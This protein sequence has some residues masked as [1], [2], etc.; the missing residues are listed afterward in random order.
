MSEGATLTNRIDAIL[1]VRRDAFL[2]HQVGS[3]TSQVGGGTYEFS[4]LL[5]R[6][7]GPDGRQTRFELFDRTARRRP[8]PASTR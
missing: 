6:V 1:D 2:V 5:L 4:M 7:F 3:G 8:S